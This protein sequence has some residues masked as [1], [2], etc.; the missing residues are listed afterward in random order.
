MRT[1]LLFKARLLN[2]PGGP[3]ADAKAFIYP[4]AETPHAASATSPEDLPDG[5]ELLWR[6]RPKAEP[7]PEPANKLTEEDLKTLEREAWQKGFE[8]ASAQARENL[9]KA[10]AAE[11]AGV[12]TA[13]S[14]FARGR[15]MYYQRIEGE[16]VRL[17]LSIAR[18][19]LHRESQIDPML[20]TGVV[21]VALEKI[22][23]GTAVKLRVPA[24]QA[25]SWISAARSL[26][27]RDLNL[28]VVADDSLSVPSCLIV[29]EMG[30]TNVSWEAQLEEIER[31]FLD[32][33]AQPRGDGHIRAA[34]HVSSGSSL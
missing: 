12:A 3:A 2:P 1:R 16:V 26:P 33:L 19:V 32:L 20:L 15:E 18:K 21:R 25:Q 6:E 10:L 8:A 28:E 22:A 27:E 14:E 11:A 4:G 13:L 23:A 34:R 17:A 29:T 9:E 24:S 31:G 5:T 30:S 7:I